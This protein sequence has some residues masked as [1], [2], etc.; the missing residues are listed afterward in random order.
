MTS[1]PKLFVSYKTVFHSKR[2]ER[3]Y[4]SDKEAKKS[5]LFELLRNF[6]R[7]GLFGHEDAF[8]EVSGLQNDLYDLPLIL[9]YLESI[10]HRCTRRGKSGH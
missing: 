4:Q 3:G 2:Q 8:I 1:K 7:S 10:A 6:D 5:H 9:R